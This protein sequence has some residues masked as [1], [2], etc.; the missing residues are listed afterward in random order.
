LL[1]ALAS[2]S[3]EGKYAGGNLNADLAW[4]WCVLFEAI[5]TLTTWYLD[6]AQIGQETYSGD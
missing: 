4:L 1:S 5:D 6:S 2:S 3:A